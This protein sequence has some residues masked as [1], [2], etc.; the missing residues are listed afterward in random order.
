MVVRDE[1]GGL[2]ATPSALRTRANTERAR[3]VAVAQRHLRV[4]FG[5]PHADAPKSAGRPKAETVEKEASVKVY[6]LRI[7]AMFA[8]FLAEAYPIVDRNH[9]SQIPELEENMVRD[10]FWDVDVR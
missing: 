4:I 5:L 6:G 8:D 2:M 9:E 10:S 1:G 7:G 3:I